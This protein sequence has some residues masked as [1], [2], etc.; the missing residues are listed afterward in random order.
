MW[1]LYTHLG[2]LIKF[3][4]RETQVTEVIFCFHWAFPFRFVT[5]SLAVYVRCATVY[6]ILIWDTI[7][8]PPPPLSLSVW[9]DGCW[10]E[11]LG[12]RLCPQTG[13]PC[14]G[15][16]LWPTTWPLQHLTDTELWDPSTRSVCLSVCLAGWLS[17]C[18]SGYLSVSI[19][20]P[21]TTW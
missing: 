12:G 19:Y 2:R 3:Q 9:G 7:A 1:G 6:E 20:L 4:G 18:L 10:P 16:R 13:L 14:S 15:A 8:Q 21:D 5:L 11:E 17:V